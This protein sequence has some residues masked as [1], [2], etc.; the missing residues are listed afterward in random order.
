MAT[1]ISKPSY[2]DFGLEAST[3]KAKIYHE[4][5]TVTVG[6]Y[7]AW[8]SEVS[9]EEV[10]SNR[11]ILTA[12]VGAD[13]T[14]KDLDG[15]ISL[16]C[17]DGVDD[18]THYVRA[19]YSYDSESVPVLSVI[20]DAIL[21]AGDD[22]HIT[23]RDR[24]RGR[25][26]AK[27][28]L[29]DN[30]RACGQDIKF[31]E[32][33]VE[34]HRLYPPADFIDYM[35]LYRVS[36]DGFLYPLYVNEN[37]NIA[38][39]NLKDENDLFLLDQNGIVLS[40]YGLTEQPL[41]Q[42]PYTYYG[43]TTSELGTNERVGLYYNVRGGELSSNGLYRYDAE[44]RCFVLDGVSDDF[45]VLKYISD[46]IVRDKMNIGS[47]GLRVHKNYQEALEAYIYKELIS[48]SRDVPANEKARALKE[49]KLALK[50]SHARDF[51]A[52]ELLQ[53]LRGN[54]AYFSSI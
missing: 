25:L 48:K 29:Q 17:N 28:W 7:P 39:S 34:G 33:A 19:V 9:L 30:G 20:D 14:K 36:D 31:A 1:F 51:K 8:I 40:S 22:S 18:F 52:G 3:K 27:R 12:T 4:Y 23:S 32:L 24:K 15:V 21:M 5:V 44:E 11:I 10:S 53:A 46:P 37:I 35:A 6:T 49:Y 43:T 38:S 50:R 13:A 42:N 16:T 45:L 47:G 54:N 2:I 41:N 26:I